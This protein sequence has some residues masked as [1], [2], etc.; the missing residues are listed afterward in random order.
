V[1]SQIFAPGSGLRWTSIPNVKRIALN[2]A[3]APNECRLHRRGNIDGII[4][5]GNKALAQQ[6]VKDTDH[7]GGV[8]FVVRD[9]C[10][11]LTG[12]FAICRVSSFLGGDGMDVPQYAVDIHKEHSTAKEADDYSGYPFL[13]LRTH[14]W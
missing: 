9:S 4:H 7:T 5:M 13:F 2:N 12:R 14:T 10:N 8:V 6:F 11:L 3:D 1:K